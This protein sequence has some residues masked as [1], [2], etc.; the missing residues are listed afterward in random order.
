MY[1]CAHVVLAYLSPGIP[2]F[3]S[4]WLEPSVPDV[5][6]DRDHDT[7]DTHHVD[8]SDVCF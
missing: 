4:N 1:E 8:D 6:Q 7:G 5:E 3:Q 2:Y